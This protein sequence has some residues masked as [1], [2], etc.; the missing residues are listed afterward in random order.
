MGAG[1]GTG[2]CPGASATGRAL[3]FVERHSEPLPGHR[4]ERGWG[5]VGG[6]VG[7]DWLEGGDRSGSSLSPEYAE[8]LVRG[9]DG[10]GL[11]A[12]GFSGESPLRQDPT[13]RVP[14]TCE[15]RFLGL[16]R[17]ELVS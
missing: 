1:A 12:E 13:A 3:G 9:K 8:R 14:R 11:D 5:G 15:P 4:R 6:G 2:W 7:W 17:P 10:K 16:R